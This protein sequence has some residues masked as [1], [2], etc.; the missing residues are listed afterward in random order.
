MFFVGCEEKIVEEA[1]VKPYNVG[2]IIVLKGVEGGER[3]L[4]RIKGG[5]ELV[6]NEKKLLMIDFFGTFCPPCQKEAQELT[7]LQVKHNKDLSL[8]GLTYL[9]DVSDEYVVDNF[10]QKYGGHYFISNNSKINAR[11]AQSVIKDISYPQGIQLPFKVLINKGK[12]EVLTDVWEGEKDTKFYIGSVS[13]SVIEQ[14][15]KKI[16]AK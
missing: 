13:T 11:I 10:A 16:L 8:I 4:K 14:D 2:D 9:E 5:F 3:K 1:E 7:K 6:G 15:M 12:Y